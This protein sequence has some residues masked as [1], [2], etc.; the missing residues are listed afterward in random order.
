VE[1]VLVVNDRLIVNGK[2]IIK[3]MT[4]DGGPVHTYYKAERMGVAG[5]YI[6]SC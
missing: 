4:L 3:V 6:L 2:G 5:N 1:R